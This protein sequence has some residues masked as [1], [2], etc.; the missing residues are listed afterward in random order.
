M[1]TTGK[2]F[3]YFAIALTAQMTIM[4]AMAIG[5]AVYPEALLIPLF[6][7][8]IEEGRL[9]GIWAGFL[10]GLL[11]DSMRA[12]DMGAQ[13]LAMT[14]VGA[15]VGLFCKK[16]FNAGPIVLFLVFFSASLIHDVLFEYS[17]GQ[18]IRV[19]VDVQRALYTALIS[20]VFLFISTI[21]RA[22]KRR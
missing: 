6:I 13:A 4:P 3:L 16:K 2:W 7:L 18:K 11:A 15:Y 17:V 19:L 5:N 8:A 14:L 22:N 1:L 10:V 20:S 21:L 9:P 12:T